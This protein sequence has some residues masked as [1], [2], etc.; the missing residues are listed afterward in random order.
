M[1]MRIAK[2][3][4]RVFLQGACLLTGLLF[5]IS[6]SK[7]AA[8]AVGATC[9]STSHCYGINRWYAGSSFAGGYTSISTVPLYTNNRGIH[10]FTHEMW[11][12]ESSGR[13]SLTLYHSC[14]I[15]VG[16][17]NLRATY[18]GKF[19]AGMFYFWA[20]MRPGASSLL[21]HILGPVESSQFGRVQNYSIRR[22]NATTYA[23]TAGNYIAYSTQNTMVANML[24]IGEELA[25]DGGLTSTS[26]QPA[27]FMHTA[28]LDM[29]GWHFFQNSGQV[30]NM[31]PHTAK[32]IG[33]MLAGGSA[34][35]TACC[36]AKWGR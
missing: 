16:Y 15:E 5:L 10:V 3:G 32:W 26:A 18:N 35:Y 19:Y 27:Y 13:C 8:Q 36:S 2:R 21:V 14:W 33:P 22:I 20:D 28:W 31:H 6:F 7:G 25:N 24:T 34:F 17:G 29:Y 30:V 12:E 1:Q 23:I 4:Q 11:L 9:M